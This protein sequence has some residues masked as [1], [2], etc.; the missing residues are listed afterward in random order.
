MGKTTASMQKK[1][2]QKIKNILIVVAYV[3][4]IIAAYLLLSYLIENKVLNRQYTA[5]VIPVGINIILAVSL[6]ITTGFLGE[7]SLGHAG[8]MAIGAYTGAFITTSNPNMN[9]VLAIAIALVA[10]GIMAA[11]FGVLIGMPVLRLRGDYLAIVTLAFGEIIRSVINSMTFLGGPAGIKRIPKLSTYQLVFVFVVITIIVSMHLKKSRHGRAIYAIREN[12]IAAE[13]MGVPVTKFKILAFTIAAF[14]AGIAGVLYAH[15]AR[16]IQ[17][18]YFDYNL[19]INI[20]VFVV[21]GG[22]GSIKGSVIAAIILTVLPEALRNFG[23]FRMITYALALIIIMIVNS[24]NLR[25]KLKT[26]VPKANVAKQ[27]GEN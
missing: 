27:K 20:L 12:Y 17:P 14:F 22:M 24:S 7:L 13:A 6:N 1:E 4:S 5:L 15:N 23:D 18:T 19:S 25:E 3:V 26:F 10:G 16:I 21:L 2:S 9:P 8:F 11:I